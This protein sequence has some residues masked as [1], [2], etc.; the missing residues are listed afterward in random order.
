MKIEKF[1]GTIEVDAHSDTAEILDEAF[2][3]GKRLSIMYG[4]HN[5]GEA[6]L[7]SFNLDTFSDGERTVRCEFRELP[8]RKP[9]AK[10]KNKKYKCVNI[11]S[12]YKCGGAFTW[13]IP[14][15]VHDLIEYIEKQNLGYEFVQ[16]VT[17]PGNVSYPD[18]IIL[19]KE[20]R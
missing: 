13:W 17:G 5:V 9:K 19:R 1:S 8:K 12:M 16:F 3:S 15:D 14:E 10:A 4:E 6:G 20:N 18:F 11:P 7:H 2:R